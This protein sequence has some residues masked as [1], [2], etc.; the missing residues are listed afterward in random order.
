[1]FNKPYCKSSD[2]SCDVFEQSF[3]SVI[4]SFHSDVDEVFTLLEYYA[5]SGVNHLPTFWN[6]V[7]VP[8]LRVISPRR[9]LALERGPMRCPETSLKDY[10]SP[11]RNTPEECLFH[12]V[13]F[14]DATSLLCSSIQNALFFRRLRRPEASISYVIYV[15]EPSYF[16][17]TH[18]DLFLW[19]IIFGICIKI[20]RRSDFS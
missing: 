12:F 19:N 13:H 9:P 5:V 14:R 15:C 1:M 11:L 17:A 7:S 6:N 18:T 16:T 20:Y 3:F 2:R 10:R 4:S 8:Y